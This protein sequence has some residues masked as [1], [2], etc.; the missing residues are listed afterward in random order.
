[1][2]KIFSILVTGI[3]FIFFLLLFFNVDD[4]VVSAIDQG[5]KGILFRPEATG[6]DFTLQS[7]DGPVSLQDMRGKVVMLYFGYTNCPAACPTTFTM[8]SDALSQLGED[9]LNRTQV[10][11]VSIDPERD[12]LPKLK[13]FTSYYH[14]NIVGVT[15]RLEVVLE[16]SDQYGALY[17]K[18]KVPDPSLG[19]SFLHDTTIF[20]I[21][22]DGKLVDS[23]QHDAGVEK[24]V[25]TIRKLLTP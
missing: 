25:E 3:L 10:I 12:T 23:F 11:F 13:E 14:P 9:E 8:I 6:G 5:E 22:P 2:K 24:I 18:E 21:S 19:Y 16:V 1:M 4:K 7:A 15:D 20:F 17:F